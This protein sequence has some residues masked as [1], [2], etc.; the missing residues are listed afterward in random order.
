MSNFHLVPIQDSGG[1]INFNP[2]T[3]NNN[4]KSLFS[5]Y[6]NDIL[7]IPIFSSVSY[8]GI[9]NNLINSP[10]IYLSP[11]SYYSPQ[12]SFVGIGTNNPLFNLD[13]N[14]S[15]NLTGSLNKNK[16]PYQN[17]QWVTNNS[18]IYF[19]NGL[20][21][22]G[23]STINN[24]NNLNG[25]IKIA[26]NIIPFSTSNYDLG[27]SDYKWRHLYLSSNSIYLD[28]ISISKSI[29]NYVNINSIAVSDIYLNSN[30]YIHI[31]N[32]GLILYN[33][34]FPLLFK[35]SF[36]NS[37]IV[38]SNVFLSSS[39][40]IYSNIISLNTNT[41]T[42]GNNNRF[43][44]NDIYNRNIT[45]TSNLI[46][47][48]IIC[49]NLTII[50]ETSFLNTSVYQTEQLQ[51]INDTTA[52]SLIVRQMNPNK[53]LAEFYNK[54]QPT[55][56][57][58]SNN[59]IGL[60]TSNPFYKLDIYGSF[61]INAELL[62][63]KTNI[64]NIIDLKISNSSN[65]LI[66]YNTHINKP[67][68]SIVGLNGNYTN[69][70]NTPFYISNNNIYSLSTKNIGIGIS[71]TSYN[72]NINGIINVNDEIFVKNTNISNI[73]DSKIIINNDYNNRINIPILNTVALSGS[74]YDINNRPNQYG[75]YSNYNNLI[76]NIWINNNINYNSN[77][78]IGN[79]NPLYKLDINGQL[80]T[81]Q[82]I[83]IK[84]TNISNIIDNKIN[85]TSNILINYN[86]YV[87]KP[88]L[89]SVA[90]NGYYS[91]LFNTPILNTVALN[92]YYS[93][94][95]NTP[96][97]ISG[98]NYYSS[99][100]N[101]LG[102]GTTNPLYKLDVNE[103]LNTSQEIL[104]KRTNISNIIDNKNNTNSNLIKT[105][106]TSLNTDLIP[107]GNNNRFISNDIYNRNIIFTQNLTTS[108][109]ITSNINVIGDS[110]VF[111][112]TVY[113][114]KKVEVDN[115]TNATS[116]KISQINSTKNLLECFNNSQLSFIINSNGNVGISNGN[117]LYKLDINGSLNTSQ[118]FLIKGTNISNIIDNKINGTSNILINYNN[119][120]NKPILKTIATSG[121]Y[122]DL[123]LN[124]FI[125]S[126]NNIYNSYIGNIGISNQNP[127]YKLHITGSLNTNQEVLIKRTNT[128]NIIDNKINIYSNILINYNN[129]I[130]LPIFKTIAFSGNYNDLTSKPVYISDYKQLNNIPFSFN[131]TNNNLL[132]NTS[133]GN[134]GIGTVNPDYK[135]VVNGNFNYTNGT[136]RISN[137]PI[138]FSTYSN[139]NIT[140]SN[141]N[142]NY[143]SNNNSFGYYIFTTSGSI[144]FPQATNCDLLVVGAGGNGGLTISSGGG[145][146][147][148][149]IYYP[150]YPFSA[151]TSNIKIGYSD[152][153]A[154]NRIT[155]INSFITA[156]GGGNGASH[157]VTSYSH[158]LI[159]KKP[160]AVYFA[161]NFANSIFFDSSG[162]NR[163]ATTT[164]T[165]TKLT[166]SGN[167]ASGS[168][169]YLLGN[170]ASTIS[171]P[172]GSIPST[173]TIL[174]LSRYNGGMRRRIL[175]S[176]G[177]GNWL[178]CHWN[179]NRGVSHYDGWITS[180]TGIGTVDNWAT[181]VSKNSGTTPG[182]IIVDGS[183]RGI[184]TGGSG[185]YNL[186]I[187]NNIYG[188]TSDWALSCVMIWNQALTDAE[189]VTLNTIVANYLSTGIYSVNVN[190]NYNDIFNSN[191]SFSGGSSGGG[192]GQ[193][194]ITQKLYTTLNINITSLS[195]SPAIAG[196]KWNNTYSYV[197]AG[198]SS[199]GAIGGNGGNAI[200]GGFIESITGTNMIMGIG[201]TGANGASI[202][203]LKYSYGNGGD[204]NGGL[205]TQ[206]VVII[207]VP[208]NISRLK[209]DG[210]INYSNIINRPYIN[211]LFTS[212]NFIDIGYY[213]QI[214]FPL[215]DTSW[216]NEWF[217]YMGTSPTNI[218][219]SFIFWHV[220]NA[221]NINS[222]WWFNG[223]TANTNNE[224]SDIRIKKEIIDI[225]NPLENLM[226]LK[227]KE[228]YLCDDKD[229]LKKYGIIAQDVK[230]ILPEFVY[231]DE[232]YIANIY[233]Y[234]K[235]YEEL[236]NNIKSYKL[237]INDTSNINIGDELKLLLNNNNNQEIIIDNSPYHNRYKKRFAIVKNIIDSKIIEIIQPLENLTELEKLNIFVYGKKVQ[238]FLKLDYSS[239]YCLNIKCNQE[240][241]KTYL[242]QQS[243][244]LLLTERILKLE[245]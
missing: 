137:V 18:N 159:D 168:I 158:V 157:L 66:D 124:P 34:K 73:I 149:V 80:N 21:G 47:S 217:L 223:T 181:M 26:G 109:L 215:A 115:N 122:N 151:G 84:K 238:N 185:G 89:T 23:S 152:T 131:T 173:F 196:T 14:G 169:T 184:A 239:L 170:T 78:G 25:N 188:E 243:K 28:N 140:A 103:S 129:H 245:S 220:N 117:P 106:I 136:M 15:I 48:N 39:N 154:N 229:Y 235:Y 56:I 226:L 120:I 9:Y 31:N 20:I 222:K 194:V 64:S 46:S 10:W 167:G 130:N 237:L 52:T 142:F 82:E 123:L 139:T 29:D 126:G 116:I 54:T 74:Y 27:S 50:G 118:E 51:V 224:I 150:N 98:N 225:I 233:N 179:G 92:G 96:F 62:I 234:G 38:L 43:I 16:N 114:S 76:N 148:E 176:A 200:N 191:A 24:S 219:N 161:E 60:G 44:I 53:N 95:N 125:I 61:N 94:L 190:N 110:T 144:T 155:N 162:N 205:G 132:Y 88:L 218:S 207:K 5:I 90:S 32:D 198:L 100:I 12:N 49:S 107:I 19:N 67:S 183:A 165:I 166:G 99:F 242:E 135:I 189:M 231:T 160:W 91:N 143:I 93:N 1:N 102:I 232:D 147:G 30:N 33:N 65:S 182:N 11:F 37:N 108:N 134:F 141:G 121:N 104:I 83:L 86:N 138:P 77:I 171:F 70:N 180:S 68:L 42:Q 71:N 164:G 210:N 146:A 187:N 145:G 208:L 201:G 63:K 186:G 87:N 105:K 35:N 228:Y 192:R 213:N 45:F 212:K 193:A 240:L 127:L 227:P 153:N 216:A 206:G 58:S 13:V 22:I 197:N 174:S 133:N 177:A 203:T 6:W 75:E 101:N 204:G 195:S 175:C 111:N 7:N 230:E 112:T 3:S 119:L 17:S 211:N 4:D 202:P 81:N 128:S 85:Y 69:L 241:Y 178:H 57:I 97:I 214:N 199:S 209:F 36:D 172:T 40:K 244:L 72:L 59:N 113:I 41:I 221:S 55:F 163:H 236:N 79:S 2:S 8:N 156:K